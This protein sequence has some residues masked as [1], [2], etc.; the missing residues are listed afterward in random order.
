MDYR[1]NNEALIACVV[2]QIVN[3]GACNV[4]RL[5]ALIPILLN[6]DFR[7]K[8]VRK[9]QI[10]ESDFYKVGM[11]YKELLVSVMNSI[12]MLIESK[13][14]ALTDE[15]LQPLKGNEILCMSMNKSSKRLSNILND[16]DQILEYFDNDTI[17]NNYK[18]FYISL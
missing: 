1:I 7:K 8:I 18:K 10:I 5:T 6:D 13:C 2:A 14:L 11:S 15:E 9:N 12:I 17:E 3:K 16:M 4:A